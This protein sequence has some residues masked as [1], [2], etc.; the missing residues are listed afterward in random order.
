MYKIACAS[1][2]LLLSLLLLGNASAGSNGDAPQEGQ[3]WIITQD[4]HVWDD[5][6]NVKDIFVSIGKTLKLENVS[7]NSVGSIQMHGET[8]WL[9]S[10]IYH[11]KRD[12]EDNISLYSKLEI[13]N[14]VLLMNATDTYYGD[15]ANVFYISKEA[16][17]VIRDYDNNESTNNDRSVIKGINYHVLGFEERNNHSVVIG[18]C[19]KAQCPGNELDPD[20]WGTES[21]IRISNSYFENIFALRAYGINAS[22]Q[23]THF[24]NSGFVGMAGNTSLFDNN[25]VTN[26][27]NYWELISTGTGIKISNNTFL[28]GSVGVHVFS[29]ENSIIENNYFSNYTAPAWSNSVALKTIDSHNL[30]ISKN[31]FRNISNHAFE[32]ANTNDTEFSLNTFKNTG[33]LAHTGFVSSGFRND[34]NNNTFMNTRNESTPWYVSGILFLRYDNVNYRGGEHNVADNF[35]YDYA[36][37]I[38]FTSFQNN[39][40]V[41]NNNFDKGF[42]AIGLWTWPDGGTTAPSGITIFNNTINNTDYPIALDFHHGGFTGTENSVISNKITN[43]GVRAIVVWSTYKNFTITDN[44]IDNST[45]GIWIFDNLWGQISNGIIANNILTNIS[46]NGISAYTASTQ[47]MENIHVTNNFIHSTNGAGIFFRDINKGYIANNTIFTNVSW[48]SQLTGIL[49]Y[50]I[51]E[52]VIKNNSVTSAVGIEVGGF[53][54]S[55]LPIIIE[56]NNLNVNDYG[57]ISNRTYTKISNNNVTGFCDHDRCNMLYLQKVAAVG[58]FSQEGEV[59]IISNYVTNFKESVTILL[60]NFHIEDNN[61]DFSEFGIIANNSDGELLSN[62]LTNTSTSLSSY[63]SSIDVEENHFRNFEKAVYA[64]NSTLS[65]E[66]NFFIDGDFCIDLVDS[67]YELITNDYS[68]RDMDYQVRYNVQIHISDESGVGSSDHL[69]EILDTDGDLVVDSLTNDDGFSAYFQLD[70]LRKVAGSEIVNFNP[71]SI[72]YDN[73]NIPVV[74]FKNITYNHTIDLLLDTQPPVTILTSGETLI[75]QQTI[76]LEVLLIDDNDDIK[77]YTIEYLVNDEFAEWEIYGTFDENSITFNGED[78]REYRFRSLGRDI[79]GNLESKNNYEYQVKI[80]TTTPDT[81]FVGFSS[82]YY[83]IGSGNLDLSWSSD[84]EDILAQNI[85]V[86]YTNFSTPYLNPNS[87]TWSLINDINVTGL[88]TYNYQFSNIGHYSFK[89]ISKDLANNI[90]QKNKFDLIF[91]YDSESDTL[92]FGNIP[93]RWGEDSI[94]IDYSTSSFNL[95]FDIYLS[96]QDIGNPSSYLTWYKYDYVT[97]DSEITLSGLKDDTRYYFYA[98]SRDLAGNIENP[99]NTTEFYSSDG[100]YDQ[101]FD[102]KYIP[103]LEW[104]YDIVIEIDDDLDGS[105]ETILQRGFDR[106]RLKSNEYFFDTDNNRI[107]FG[108]LSNGGFVPSEDLSSSNNVKISYSGVQGI[109]EVFTGEPETASAL[110]IVPSNT[111]ELVVSFVVPNDSQICK[112]QRTTNISKGFFNEMIIEPCNEGQIEYIHKNPDLNEVYYYR[113]LIED[114]FG[115]E[116]ISENRSIDMKDVV[117]L[118]SSTDD[119]NAGLLGMDSIIPITALVGIIMLGFGGVLLYRSRNNDVFDENVTIVES[120]PVAKYKVEELYLIYKDGRLVKNLSDVEVKTDSDIMSGMLTA[121]NDF[122]QD[123]FNTEGDLGSIDYG[124]NKIILQRGQNSYLAAVVYGEVDKF[125]KGKMINAVRNIENVNPTMSSWNGDSE[126]ILH[127]EHYLQPIIDETKQSTKEMVDNYFSEKEIVLTTSYDKI[128]NSVELQV[129]MSNYSPGVIKNCSLIPEFNSSNLSLVGIEPDV[130]YS[131]SDNSFIVGEIESYNEVSFKLKF[132]VK[133]SGASPIEIR[134][135]YEQ[136]GR[137]GVSS[138]LIEIV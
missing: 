73:N 107:V 118:Y 49:G 120:K 78:G 100:L 4:T 102:L 87:V 46:G 131:F 38:R 111:T 28:N 43:T 50:F 134:M 20:L 48:E 96:L 137:K 94:T 132:K 135:N 11:D 90:E 65:L 119:S 59:D 126:T 42:H 12:V 45:E 24:N 113:I 138:S 83:F 98:V 115:H 127:T 89:I 2:A 70:I 66:D 3:D 32:L 91:N 35:F 125:F 64:Y 84:D 18:H 40:T 27:W 82:D 13:I 68:C 116:S 105:Y 34:I 56:E 129:N 121:I 62:I 37:A 39:I 33:I 52:T 5:D 63:L 58:I 93:N 104:N 99:L 85:E 57:I 67:D 17:L 80:D 54:N 81:E 9:N 88:E 55:V 71:F 124:N 97:V 1:F 136:K 117:K 51:P 108:G 8:E 92:N 61:I 77:D 25:L 123:S 30:T 76:N 47:T 122:V 103:L 19:V 6:V 15:N 75:N 41:K 31:Y 133:T 36:S 79:Y 29:S 16:E 44:Y 106:S 86:Y 23:N 130:F 101:V 112:V 10:S 14:T 95:D 60:A 69:F 22:I 53:A 109:F 114:E 72:T 110:N 21:G 74:V 26:S 7:L 128:D